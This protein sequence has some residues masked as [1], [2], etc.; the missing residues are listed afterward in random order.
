MFLTGLSGTAL[1]DHNCNGTA[2][3][4]CMSRPFGVPTTLDEYKKLRAKWKNDPWNGAKLFIAAMLARQ[5]NETEGNKMA[6]MAAHRTW[7]L[8]PGN[9]YKGYAMRRADLVYYKPYCM[10]ALVQGTSN[11]KGYAFDPKKV[12]IKYRVQTKRNS[13]PTSK[14]Y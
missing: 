1:A 2:A 5:F 12:V 3:G 6:V 14:K 13:S 4:D 8:G 9:W 10:R 11:K 7:L